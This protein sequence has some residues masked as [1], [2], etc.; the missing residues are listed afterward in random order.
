MYRGVK[1]LA[2]DD[3]DM[4]VTDWTWTADY[5]F[6][7]VN[8][9]TLQ[10]PAHNFALPSDSV[11]D[12][13]TIV[14]VPSSPGYGL[15]QAEAAALRAEAAAQVALDVKAMADAG[16][17]DGAQGLPGN[18][19]MRVD[20]TVG[21]RVFIT[22]GVTEKMLS[23]DTG[24]R[25][26]QLKTGWSGILKVKR[27]MNTVYWSGALVM[28]STGIIMG[29]VPSDGFTVLAGTT[30]NLLGRNSDSGAVNAITVG[31][32]LA[33]AGTL[34]AG[35]RLRFEGSYETESAWPTTLPGTPA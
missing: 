31:G 21:T 4:A 3:P 16:E 2:T 9:V 13:T 33:W 8:G 35:Q 25:M 12:L 24:W 18:A 7:S 11:V 30:P 17:F 26:I 27:V 6:E 28:P 20:T 23:G 34:V 14:K 32:V 29:D 22:D 19:T 5:R 15:P 1:L 10:I